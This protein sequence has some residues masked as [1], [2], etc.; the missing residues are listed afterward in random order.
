MYSL[1]APL[2][3]RAY[4][5]LDIPPGATVCRRTRASLGEIQ[6]D[7][8]AVEFIAKQVLRKV[9]DLAAPE[10]KIERVAIAKLYPG[11]ITKKEELDDFIGALRARLEKA[12]AAKATV[13]LE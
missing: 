7:L 8:E 3:Q 4:P 5:E 13:I 9:I 1:L 10:E 6:S 12:L 2:Y 11:R